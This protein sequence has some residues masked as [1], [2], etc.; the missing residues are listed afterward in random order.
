MP[1][2]PMN[3]G[4]V[5]QT[6]GPHRFRSDWRRPALYALAAGAGPDDLHLL[7]EPEPR[8]LP[9]FADVITFPAVLEVAR[10]LGGELG[11]RLHAAQRLTVHRP[12]PAAAEFETSCRVR[13]IHD[14]GT[15]ALVVF[16]T[17]TVARRVAAQASVDPDEPAAPDEPLF[18]SE[19]HVLYRGYGRFG[20]SRAPE[21]SPIV[22]PEGQPPDGRVE[23]ATAPTLA[24]LHRILSDDLNPLHWDPAAA[25]RMGLPR[26][27]LHGVCTLGHATRAAAQVLAGKDPG[28][29]VTVEA[30]FLK[31]VFP[32]D[33]LVT[34]VWRTGPGRAIVGTRTRERE[35]RV[36][37]AQVEHHADDLASPPG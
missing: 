6:F 10:A 19:W 37:I 34:E 15:A 33:T 31:P 24:H 26:P 1:L 27:V 5:G 14:Q 18:E 8:I 23:V 30:R 21:A 32:G 12:I 2:A 13:D 16:A 7:L 17:S 22:V 20:G 3:F 36:L 25:R 11:A 29:L 35:D 28:L 4:I 9:T